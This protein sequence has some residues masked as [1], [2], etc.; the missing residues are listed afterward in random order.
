MPLKKCSNN[1]KSGWKW[2][3]SGKCFTGPSGKKKAISQG[4]AIEGPE[5]FRKKESK[6]NIDD[7]D[8]RAI[9]EDVDSTEHEVEVAMS[10]LEYTVVQRMNVLH[11]RKHK[12]K[13]KKKKKSAY[14]EH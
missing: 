7:D 6:A 2:G 14:G 12:K 8:L 13:K 4:I 9:L 3:S 5:G 11:A 1:G 10:A